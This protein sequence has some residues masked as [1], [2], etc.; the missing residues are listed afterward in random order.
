MTPTVNNQLHELVL[1][2]NIILEY[3]D[4][5]PSDYLGFYLVSEDLPRPIIALNTLVCESECLE[6][7]VLAEELG[8]HFT[9]ELGDANR[10]CQH[11]K[12][13]LKIDKVEMAALKW[14]G[15]FL[16]PVDRIIEAVNAHYDTLELLADYFMVTTQF[17]MDWFYV[18]SLRHSFIDLGSGKKIILSSYPNVLFG[19]QFFD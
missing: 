4:Q 8:H 2:E 19:C 3:T 17:V 1:K 7:V 9:A 5:L 15:D 18:L 12:G 14:S 13:R 11:F 16:M 6:N 10:L